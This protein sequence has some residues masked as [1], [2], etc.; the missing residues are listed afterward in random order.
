MEEQEYPQ[1]PDEIP[2]VMNQQP[3]TDGEADDMTDDDVEGG[4]GN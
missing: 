2:F 1:A 4:E 3:E